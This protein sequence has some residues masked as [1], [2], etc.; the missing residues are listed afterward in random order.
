MP[1]PTLGS[2]PAERGQFGFQVGKTFVERLAITLLA[3]GFEV[4]Q[5]AGTVEEQ[6]IPFLSDGRFFRG[7]LGVAFAVARSSRFNLFL[8]R[9]TFPTTCHNPSL[10]QWTL[11]LPAG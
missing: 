3:A 4:V 1:R 6:S 7:Q 11:L 10:A 8:N 5:H 2:N 9:L